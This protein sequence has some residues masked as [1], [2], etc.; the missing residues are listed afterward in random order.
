MEWRAGDEDEVGAAIPWPPSDPEAGR[1]ARTYIESP[2]PE[3][4]LDPPQVSYS[5]MHMARPPRVPFPVPE[6]GP[7]IWF[8]TLCVLHRAPC[9]AS[10]KVFQSIT[11]FIAGER[12][13]SILALVVMPDHIHALVTPL[14]D[15]DA[16]VT[17]VTAGLK[18][19]V[20]RQTTASWHW[21]WG[22]FDR[23]LRTE[24]KPHEKWVYMRENPVRAGLVRRWEDW[25]WKI[26]F[27]V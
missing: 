20:R 21:Q 16:P 14:V 3:N 4:A 8:I 23:L 1:N 26:G 5:G 27:A 13:W 24:E 10:E 15:R 9:L 6:S 2:H 7:V 22:A 25:P 11:D 12:R 17:Q 18:R 19:F